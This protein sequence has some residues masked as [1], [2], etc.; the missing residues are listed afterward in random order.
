MAN[1]HIQWLSPE[2]IRTHH[3]DNG[4][5]WTVYNNPKFSDIKQG[6]LGNCWLLSG[7][8]VIL[9][10]PELLAKI[11]ITKE[12]CPQGCYLVRLCHN[13]EWQTV[14]LDDLFP[15]DANGYLLY[16]QVRHARVLIG[17][18]LYDQIKNAL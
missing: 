10:Q 2:R 8:A 17:C 6:L 9:E 11:I 18:D 16:S 13:G 3:I 7:L 5:K 4:F 1:K 15:C 14:L 12:H